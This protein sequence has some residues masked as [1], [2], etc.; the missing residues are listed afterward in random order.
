MK[1]AKIF[2]IVMV[3]LLLAAPAWAAKRKRRTGAPEVKSSMPWMATGYALAGLAGICVVGFKNSK[4]T[5]L[6]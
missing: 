5:H 1:R 6:D 3:L 2:V 4:R